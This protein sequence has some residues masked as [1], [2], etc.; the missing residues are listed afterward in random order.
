M[1]PHYKADPISFHFFFTQ[2]KPEYCGLARR[3]FTTLLKENADSLDQILDRVMMNNATVGSFY[4]PAVELLFA[5]IIEAQAAPARPQTVPVA[6]GDE[7]SDSLSPLSRGV[8]RV[9]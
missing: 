7:E 9:Q 8:Y 1:D 4:D 2:P 6:A 3:Q 5:F